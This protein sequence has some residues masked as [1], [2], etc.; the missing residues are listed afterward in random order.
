MSIDPQ[1]VPDDSLDALISSLTSLLERTPLDYIPH[2]ANANTGFP[3]MV[4]FHAS[5]KKIRLLAG[6]NRSGKTEAGAA[7]T[8][9]HAT[10][11][12]PEWYPTSQRIL[13]PTRG[14]VVVGD[15]A[16]ACGE[17]LEPK[18]FSWLPKSLIA[19]APRRTLKGF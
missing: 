1:G 5:P 18:I 10:G 11:L 8:L 13:R 6:G 14:R 19:R 7:E 9:F 3:G 17:V 4:A 12:Y 2:P 15:Y 16:K